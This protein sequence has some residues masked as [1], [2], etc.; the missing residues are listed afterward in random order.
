VI[1]GERFLPRNR[2]TVVWLWEIYLAL[3][4]VQTLLLCLG[5]MSLFDSLCIAFG[6]ISTGGYAPLTA[7]VGHFNSAYFDW[8]ITIFMMRSSGNT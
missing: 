5:G 7:S 8:V 3:N 4:L 1:T 6:T 2:D